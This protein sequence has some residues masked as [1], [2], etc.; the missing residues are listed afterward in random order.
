MS[1]GAKTAGK[2]IVT[3]AERTGAALE[4]IPTTATEQAI[5]LG[6]GLS[7]EAQQVIKSN[8][9]LYKAARTGELTRESLFTDTKA[10]LDKSIDDLS[11][12][13]KSYKELRR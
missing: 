8:P 2:A 12:L 9:K 4:K 10:A 11:E 7:K 13:G 6:T 1:Q 5:S 3:G